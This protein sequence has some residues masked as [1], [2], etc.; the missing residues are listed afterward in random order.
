MLILSATTSLSR[1]VSLDPFLSFL[2]PLPLI[3]LSLLQMIDC[4]VFVLTNPPTP[5]LPFIPFMEVLVTI[6]VLPTSAHADSW[7]TLSTP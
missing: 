1:P 3:T 2:L 4:F 5:N 7:E 6:F